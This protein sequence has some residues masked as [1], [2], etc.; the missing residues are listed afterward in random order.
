MLT[1]NRA[2]YNCN[3]FTQEQIDQPTRL[4]DDNDRVWVRELHINYPRTVG[5][6]TFFVRSRHV[7]NAGVTRYRIY[8]KC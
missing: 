4:S 8:H 5:T 2:P 3:I 6:I 7:F 1:R